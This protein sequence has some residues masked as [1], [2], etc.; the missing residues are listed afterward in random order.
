MK[1]VKKSLAICFLLST[2]FA[3]L[4]WAQCSR[5]FKSVLDP[6]FLAFSQAGVTQWKPQPLTN[7]ETIL[8]Y[9]VQRDNEIT[10][11]G[12]PDGTFFW[13]P[14][15]LDGEALYN[16]RFSLETKG[17]LKL[18]KGETQS[19]KIIEIP[20]SLH[21]RRNGTLINAGQ[22]KG[23]TFLKVE[24]STILKSAQDGDELI[25]EPVN[26]EDWPAKRIVKIGG[27]C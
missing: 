3:T 1:L 22:C 5:S 27:G 18:I 15:M 11:N 14:L 16:N 7:L 26:K 9:N 21:L 13:K 25:V 24:I 6:D 17:E 12:K 23:G 10:Y 2:C 19:G 8:G 20:F 4:T